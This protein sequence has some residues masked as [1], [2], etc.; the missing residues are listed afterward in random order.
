M[1]RLEGERQKAQGLMSTVSV[2]GLAQ[3]PAVAKVN[4]RNLVESIG[5]DQA[6]TK[7]RYQIAD[8]S[9]QLARDDQKISKKRIDL[10]RLPQVMPLI[11]Q[12]APPEL[13]A[14][15]ATSNRYYFLP[16]V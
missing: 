2:K 3:N 15:H 5:G 12:V 10:S 16:F 14:A 6:D 11:D 4:T 1:P 8:R 13:R 7:V 9:K